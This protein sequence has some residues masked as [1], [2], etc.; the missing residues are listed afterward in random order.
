MPT[1]LQ[2]LHANQFIHLDLFPSNLHLN[3]SREFEKFHLR[4]NLLQTKRSL[5]SQHTSNLSG[6][7][8]AI[9]AKFNRKIRVHQTKI[10]FFAVKKWG[11]STKK[12]ERKT[13]FGIRN[14]VINFLFYEKNVWNKKIKGIRKTYWWSVSQVVPHKFKKK[15]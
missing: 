6:L 12:S 11:R 9:C 4:R 15:H 7:P 5:F 10:F 1:T 13:F 3:Y 14:W 8:A 2:D